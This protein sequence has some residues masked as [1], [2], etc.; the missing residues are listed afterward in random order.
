MACDLQVICT[1]TQVL[2]K[3]KGGI[4][5][6]RPKEAGTQS[7]EPTNRI[8]RDGSIFITLQFLFILEISFNV[9]SIKEA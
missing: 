2:A 7:Y 8:K 6:N 9:P 3:G 5:R 1:L 4:V